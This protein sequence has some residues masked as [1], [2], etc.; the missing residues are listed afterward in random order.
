MNIQAL[1][2]TG[3][4]VSGI[5]Q[6]TVEINPR[7]MQHIY[8]KEPRICVSVNKTP[9]RSPYSLLLP[10]HIE[11]KVVHQELHVIS[12]L[13]HPLLLG[14]DFLKKNKAVLNFGNDT[15]TLENRISTRICRPQWHNP[16]PTHLATAEEVTLEPNSCTL[17]K[18]LIGGPDPRIKQS[19]DTPKTMT[20]RPLAGDHEMEL[21]VIAAW[22]IVD[23]KQ[24]EYFIEV[25]NPCPEPL[26]LPV[27]VPVAMAENF[28]AEIRSPQ[29]DATET[30]TN[31]LPTEDGDFGIASMM[32][33]DPQQTTK[34]PDAPIVEDIEESEEDFDKPI[35]LEEDDKPPD[36]LQHPKFKINWDAPHSALD[37]EWK[38]K[39]KELYGTY[40]KVVASHPHDLGLTKLM[41]HYVT[42]TT[43]KPVYAP[44]YKTPPPDVRKEIDKHTNELIAMG[45]ARES[46]SPYSAPIVL[47]RKKDGLWRYCTDFRRLNRITESLLPTPEHKRCSETLQRSKGLYDLGSFEGLSSDRDQRATQK[48]FRFL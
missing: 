38:G 26:T 36:K 31:P 23:L 44:Y 24:D 48:V 15:M 21:P 32:T 25:M 11:G 43:D 47:V 7:L 6:R 30:Q 37:D 13:I 18:T 46:T 17:V 16:T 40:N 42:L 8:R 29:T 12:N 28:D 14:V 2:D 33:E 3:A 35:P 1:I 4:D 10:I 41:R 9:L 20:V 34:H 39:F 22:G 45:V 27:G 5:S 19:G